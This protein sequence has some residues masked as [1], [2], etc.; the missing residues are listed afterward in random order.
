MGWRWLSL[1]V[2]N[3]EDWISDHRICQNFRLN[4]HTKLE[5]ALHGPAGVV[6][7]DDAEHEAEKND[8]HIIAHGV[9]GDDVAPEL[10]MEEAGPDEGEAD[11]RH[12][13]YEAHQDGEVRNH[14]SKDYGD[15][16]DDNPEGEAPHLEFAV[17]RPDGWES[18]LGLALVCMRILFDRSQ[19][20]GYIRMSGVSKDCRGGIHAT[21]RNSDKY[22]T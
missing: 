19:E 18:R 5:G 6:H 11:A 12:V 21:P 3:V 14:H 2:D 10:E 17:Q 16:H 13:S 8:E 9:P 1:K 15:H 7:A 4:W 22:G 20:H